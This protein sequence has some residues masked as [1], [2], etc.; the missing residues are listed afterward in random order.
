[1]FGL[2]YME[3]MDYCF[4]F[5]TADLPWLNTFTSFLSSSSD[6]S[7]NSYLLFYS[8]MTLASTFLSAFGLIS[9]LAIILLAI[10][11]ICPQ[12]RPTLEIIGMFFYNFF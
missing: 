10:G 9:L 6:L 7:P 2:T 12:N 5:L 4:G 8:N 3:Y 11:Y 1:M